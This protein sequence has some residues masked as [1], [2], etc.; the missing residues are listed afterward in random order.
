M[1]L[2]KTRRSLNVD[3][4]WF[5]NLQEYFELRLGQVT[6]GAVLGE[7]KTIRVEIEKNDNPHGLFA[8]SRHSNKLFK[9]ENPETEMT[10]NVS[11]SRKYGST[12]RIEVSDLL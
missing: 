11:L 2:Y 8:V 4:H 1:N 6:G 5:I 7:N 10:V 3:I 9:M 12:G